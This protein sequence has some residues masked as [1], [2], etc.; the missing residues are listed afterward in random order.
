MAISAKLRKK[1]EERKKQLESKGGGLKGMIAFKTGKTRIRLLNVG[2][3]DFAIETIQFYFSKELGG[4]ISPAT[5]GLKCAVWDAYN[6]MKAGDEDDKALSETFKPRRRYLAPAIKYKDE[7][8]KEVDLEKGAALAIL[9]ND[10]YAE[11]VDWMLDEEDYGDFTDPLEGYDIKINRTGEGQFD[12]KYKLMKCDSTKAPKDFR[13]VYSGEEMVKALLP[14]YEE[15]QEMLN[16][17][18]GVTDEDDEDE[19]PKKK[20]KKKVSKEDDEPV[21]KKKKK[22]KK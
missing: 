18:L 22:V 17:F 1:M 9:T 13:K 11:L 19:K 14:T 8:G 5:F 2:E 7:K 20:K 15:T 12:T 16:K 10:N 3:E 21:K 6:E 4:M